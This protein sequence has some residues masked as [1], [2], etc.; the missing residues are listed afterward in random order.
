[1]VFHITT[2]TAWELAAGAGVYRTGSLDTEGFIHCSTA[3]QVA[4]TANRLFAGR[5]DVVLLCIDAARLGSTLR[6][7][8]AAD[9]PGTVFPHVFGPIA[10]DAVFE[11]VSLEP[12]E[13]RFA[14]PLEVAALAAVGDWTAERAE[15]RATAVMA[16]YSAPWWIAGGW[17]LELHAAMAHDPPI[18]PHADLEI[19]VLRRDQRA[20]FEQLAGWQI[21]TVVRPGVLEP[22]DGAALPADVHQLWARR[23][24]SLPSELG[25]IA[26]D[27]TRLEILFEASDGDDW[28][29]RRQRSI[30]RPLAEL[31]A[32][33]TR[34]AGFL[35][36]EI[37]LLYKAKHLRRKDERDFAAT[38]PLLD[39]TSRAWLATALDRVHPA[40][41]WRTAL[42]R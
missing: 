26:A 39:A 23:G 25:Q 10:L 14:V 7:E 22:W 16:G 29:F 1:M 32:L 2:R 12:V 27:P 30:A 41:A 5:T 15:A 33:T 38:L 28:Q 35:R 24:S 37:A 4:A 19:A 13:G 17:A 11:V 18:R 36:P 20:L 31:G 21:W 6:Y 34:G 8:P 42:A 9:L 3:E 40:H